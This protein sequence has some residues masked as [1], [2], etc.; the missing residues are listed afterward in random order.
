MGTIKQ[1]DIK[2]MICLNII[3]AEQVAENVCQDHAV[4]LA[5]AYIYNNQDIDTDE[6]VYINRQCEIALR[7]ISN[8]GL[9]E[10]KNKALHNIAANLNKR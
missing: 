10:A 8:L 1:L 3:A 6:I 7:N 5:K 4:K 9:T 2:Q